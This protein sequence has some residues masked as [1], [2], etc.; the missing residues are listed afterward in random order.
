MAQ[1]EGS[2]T[3]AP[4]SE[5][6]ALKFGLPLLPDDVRADAQP[7]GIEHAASRV[8]LCRSVT[9]TGMGPGAADDRFRRRQPKEVAV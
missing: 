3:T 6:A 1:V 5:N 2:G 7:V 4:L 9:Q 8:Q